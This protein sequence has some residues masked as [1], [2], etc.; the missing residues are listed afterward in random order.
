MAISAKAARPRG[1][2][3]TRLRRL[4]WRGRKINWSGYVFV[5][6]FSIFFLLL[7]VGALAF[8]LY[9]AFN[10]WEVVGDIEWVG[11]A[12]FEEIFDDRFARQAFLNTFRYVLFIVP[13]VT[14]VAFTF[15]WFVHQRWPG[16]SFARVAFFTP[17]VCAPTVV[18]LIWVWMLDTQF[19]LIN[20][21]LG[22]IGIP[23]VPWLTNPD[24]SWVGVG[25]TTIWWD[26]GFSF[27][28]FLAALQD[29][30]VELEEAAIVDGANRWQVIRHVVLPHLRPV[31]SMVITL[32]VIASLRIFSQ[33]VVMTSGGPAGSSTSAIHYLYQRGLQESRFGYAAAVALLVLIVTLVVTLMNRRLLREAD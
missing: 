20:Q 2:L 6:P 7:K 32:Q 27:I 29:V 10:K 13:G 23:N 33:I 21:Y 26:T 12:N 4:T 5:A 30:P 18:G 11:L 8:G 19:G 25:L 1:N 14:A 16:N 3:V 17:F 22:N 31:T 9:L 24:W 15:A 28:L